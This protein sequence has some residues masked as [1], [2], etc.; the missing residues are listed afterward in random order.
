MPNPY[1]KHFDE[2]SDPLLDSD[3]IPNQMTMEIPDDEP[4]IQMP[5]LP[6]LTDAEL[7]AMLVDKE[8]DQPI[9]EIPNQMVGDHK[10]WLEL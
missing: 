5:Q 2:D 1:F 6:G 3:G 9:D 4:E 7:D 10:D 8:G